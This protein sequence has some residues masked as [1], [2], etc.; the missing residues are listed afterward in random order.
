MVYSCREE[1][2]RL[3]TYLAESKHVKIDDKKSDVN[4][5][6]KTYSLIY[7]VSD[8]IA[9]HKRPKSLIVICINF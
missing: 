2:K 4:N 3:L 7:L 6:R 1:S 8:L 9:N 5:P